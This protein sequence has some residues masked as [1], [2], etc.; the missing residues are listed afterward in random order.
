MR[1]NLPKPD[2]DSGAHR[3]LP[4][5][6]TALVVVLPSIVWQL[7]AMLDVGL[8]VQ[9]DSVAYLALGEHLSK[10]GGF[11]HPWFIARTPGYP[12]LL[13]VAAAVGG[14]G[15][16]T[17]VLLAQHG[18]VVGCAVIMT[19]LAWRL[20]HTRSVACACGLLTGCSWALTG[21]AGTVLTEAPYTF[22]LLASL[23]CLCRFVETGGLQWTSLGSAGLGCAALIRPA[24]LP[25][26]LLPAAALFFCKQRKATAAALSFRSRWFAR[27]GALLAAAGPFA[28]LTG[29]WSLI[30]VI[31]H[32]AAG[33]GNFAGR[34]LYHRVVT[35]GGWTTPVNAAMED[36]RACVAKVNATDPNP[37]PFDA[38]MEEHA[39]ICL[40]RVHG[41]TLAEA[42]NQ[43][44]AA[45]APIFR[46]HAW[47]ILADTP[48]QAA[49]VLLVPDEIHRFRAEDEC[50]RLSMAGD[51]E[52]WPSTAAFAQ[53]VRRRLREAGG[54]WMPDPRTQASW[55]S[56]LRTALAD[57]YDRFVLRFDLCAPLPG[58]TVFEN[59]VWLCLLGAITPL[60]GARRRMW[61]ITVALVLLQVLPCAFAPGF[62]RRFAA[63]I[64]P[65]VH[66]WGV[67]LVVMVG[68]WVAARFKQCLVEIGPRIAATP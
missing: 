14:A 16:S 67:Q 50:L 26:A 1:Q 43:L 7:T 11:E 66:L 28:L 33:A 21:Y 45:V 32:G 53:D 36:I 60:A 39:V 62:D 38:R 6:I 65:V 3:L 19:A 42:S 49:Y 35:R 44:G 2:L 30:T 68:Q 58:D 8:W 52:D 24:A 37:P 59:W 5:W 47:E 13:A 34:T 20:S 61:V 23:Y 51:P 54:E 46:L 27:C 41:C 4:W 57:A 56:P 29:G 40:Q 15:A 17:I 63:P 48:R 64:R 55:I 25:L 10:G 12:L 31:E 22:A 9:P 18:I